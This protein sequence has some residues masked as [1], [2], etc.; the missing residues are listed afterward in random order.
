MIFCDTSVE[1]ETSFWTHRQTETEQQTDWPIAIEVSYLCKCLNYASLMPPTLIL[2][3]K[4]VFFCHSA[5]VQDT[6]FYSS[7]LEGLVPGVLNTP[8]D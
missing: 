7:Y 6:S 4:N 3:Y 2:W 1:I 5:H 8:E